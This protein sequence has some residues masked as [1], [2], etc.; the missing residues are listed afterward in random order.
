MHRVDGRLICLV[1]VAVFLDE[2]R[3]FPFQLDPG[4]VAVLGQLTQPLREGFL[5]LSDLNSR[6]LPQDRDSSS[7]VS[8]ITPSASP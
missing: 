8:R 2:R 3:A 4:R 5:R 7:F 6:V 1:L